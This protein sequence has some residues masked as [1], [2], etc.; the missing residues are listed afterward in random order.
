MSPPAGK[1]CMRGTSGLAQAIIGLVEW[2]LMILLICFLWDDNN[3]DSSPQHSS[4]RDDACSIRELRTSL[5]IW[6]QLITHLSKTYRHVSPKYCGWTLI[7]IS[8]ESGVLW[9][10]NQVQTM[11]PCS[12]D[13][14]LRLQQCRGLG[15]FHWL[16]RIGEL[17]VKVDLF[18]K[19]RPRGSIVIAR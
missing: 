5:C 4:H 11:F 17:V 1:I 12:R 3:K 8:L 2:R 16:D 14:L 10:H 19:V 13:G 18:R 15:S 9:A 6:F 7:T